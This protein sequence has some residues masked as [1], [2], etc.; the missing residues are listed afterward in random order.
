MMPLR[1]LEEKH[2]AEW[3]CHACGEP[4]LMTM[5]EHFYGLGTNRVPHRWKI[6]KSGFCKDCWRC[7]V[8]CE[9]VQGE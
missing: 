7:R 1:D 6:K 5:A 8:C 2:V 9:C 3:H 4:A